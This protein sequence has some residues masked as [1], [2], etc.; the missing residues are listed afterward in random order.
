[1]AH[2]LLIDKDTN[3]VV[4]VIEVDPQNLPFFENKLIVVTDE[5]GIDW[6]WD[7]EKAVAPPPPPPPPPA[8]QPTLAELQ[9]KLAALSAQIQSLSQT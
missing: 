8:P 4:N 1:M 6:T 5:G 9:A 7:G 2:A 3:I